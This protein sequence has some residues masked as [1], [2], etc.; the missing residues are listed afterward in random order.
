MYGITHPNRSNFPTIITFKHA[1]HQRQHIGICPFEMYKNRDERQPGTASQSVSQW[2]KNG[3][4]SLQINANG[5]TAFKH[6]MAGQKMIFTPLTYKISLYKLS[7]LLLSQRA[8]P[9]VRFQLPL[10]Y[11]NTLSHKSQ[12]PD[13]WNEQ[14]EGIHFKFSSSSISFYLFFCFFFTGLQETSVHCRID[15]ASK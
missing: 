7:G 11:I 9:S 14:T 15:L 1:N 3:K 2:R 5:N 13:A 10:T 4:K 8:C 12:F 6:S